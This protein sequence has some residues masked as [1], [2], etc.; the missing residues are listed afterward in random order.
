L[1]VVEVVENDEMNR[2]IRG[3][4]KAPE[5]VES[6][7][8]TPAQASR[9]EEYVKLGA[10]YREARDLVLGYQSEPKA[11]PVDGNAG[12]GTGERSPAKIGM[13]DW[14]R[15]ALWRHRGG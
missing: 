12:S 8:L 1:E 10:A 14:I 7:Q 2:F 3:Q 4:V 5:T 9:I 6:S 11:K 13:N 15:R